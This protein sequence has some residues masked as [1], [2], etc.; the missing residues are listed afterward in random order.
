MCHLKNIEEL[1]LPL[2]QPSGGETEQEERL[3]DA[4]GVGPVALADD[5]DVDDVVLE[6]QTLKRRFGGYLLL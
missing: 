5:E 2:L 6:P 3:L 1:V 4:A